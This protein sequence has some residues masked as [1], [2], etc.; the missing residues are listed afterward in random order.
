MGHCMPI[1]SATSARAT[2][3]LGTLA[4]G[5]FLAAAPVAAQAPDTLRDRFIVPPPPPGLL[6]HGLLILRTPGISLGSPVGF[7]PAWGDVFVGALGVN[8]QRYFPRR[9]YR[10]GVAV[11]GFGLGDPIDLVGL[12]VLLVSYSTWNTGLL[13]RAGLAMKAHR[14]LPGGFAAGVG[15][16]N[17]L[18]RGDVDFDRSVYGVLS[19]AWLPGGGELP[20]ITTSVGVGNGRFRSEEDWI[21]DR[22]TV[23]VFGNVAVTPWH[24]VS[25]IADYVQDLHLGVSIIPL[26][27]VPLSVT[28]GVLDVL[29]RAGDGQRF[30]IGVASGYNF[31]R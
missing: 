28:L 23:G 2:T 7:G 20:V 31:A 13:S 10:D 29:E 17:I 27:R 14:A 3:W 1:P 11:A 12:E 25:F 30:M 8:R 6:E 16:E 18:H 19:R 5:L 4:A 24:P 22:N 9:G 15:M 21:E 26:R